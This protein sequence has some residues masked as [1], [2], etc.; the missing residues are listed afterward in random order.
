MSS[1]TLKLEED[2]QGL[3]MEIELPDTQA[4]WDTKELIQRGDLSGASF[5]F[6]NTRDEW[7][8][9]GPIPIRTLMSMDLHDVGPV[10]FPAYAETSVGI[11]S[12]NQK[13]AT[14]VDPLAM[15]K[16]RLRLAQAF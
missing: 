10:T 16:L 9:D 12:L 14:K 3:R 15:Y 8:L 13:Q 7:A 4:G 1:G 11:R 6:S 5:S 2:S